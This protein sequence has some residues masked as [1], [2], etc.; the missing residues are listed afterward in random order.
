MTPMSTGFTEE[1]QG[2]A[3]SPV[4]MDYIPTEDERRVF[5][6]CNQ[7]SFWYRSV[8]FSVVSM[9]VTQGLIH[10]GALTSSSKFGSLP[11]VAF[12]GLCGYLAGKISYMK[13]CQ[14]K[15]KRLEHS[16]LGEALRQRTRPNA[17]SSQGPQSE[18][19]DPDQ[20]TFDPMFQASDPQSQVPPHAR[21][22]GYSDAP[23]AAQTSRTAADID[24][25]MPAQSFLDDEEP[26][27]KPI[28]YE[29]L[30]NK[31]RETYEVTLT[32]KAET[33][34][35]PESD[36]PGRTAPKKD[37]GKKNVYGDSLEE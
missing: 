15:F 25:N 32:Q 35:K 36:R 22:Y 4:G 12:A 8:P 13:H 29:D 33:L 16:P 1:R 34:L 10:R 6:E 23:T 31:N 37:A 5:R 21:D 18:M 26:R 11:K 14:E 20:V 17:Q 7:E 3:Q 24:Y 19:S 27:R 28:M 2:E 9:L 30:R